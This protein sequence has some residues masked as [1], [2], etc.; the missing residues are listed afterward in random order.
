MS[1]VR[2]LPA[3]GTDAY[4]C[5]RHAVILGPWTQ[6]APAGSTV[7]ISSLV[8][9]QSFSYR[10]PMDPMEE[11]IEMHALIKHS[12]TS[13]HLDYIEHLGLGRNDPG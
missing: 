9:M 3:V 10:A 1:D 6:E 2:A 11:V 5:A 7:T 13:H 4:T 12:G 8:I